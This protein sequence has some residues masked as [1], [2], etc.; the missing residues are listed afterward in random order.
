MV[1]KT[2]SPIGWSVILILFLISPSTA[3]GIKT[4]EGAESIQDVID[5]RTEIIFDGLVAFRRDLHR[6]PELSG[7]EKRTAKKITE[8]L[9]SLGLE[10][11]TGIGGHGVVGILRGGEKGRKI[12]WRADIDALKSDSPDVVEFASTNPGVRHI[13]GHDVH[14]A[15]GLGIADVLAA[16]RERLPGTVYFV[17][18]PSEEN[19]QGA[20]A[21]IDDG[22]FKSIAPEEFYALHVTPYPEGMIVSRPGGMFA[23]YGE[24]EIEY[25]SG[26]DSLDIVESVKKVLNRLETIAD[27]EVF[28]NPANWGDPEIGLVSP[29][30]IYGDYVSIHPG[31]Y[32]REEDNKLLISVNIGTTGSEL[33]KKAMK[34]L[35][36]ELENSK[37]SKSFKGMKYLDVT[38][39]P[40]NDPGLVKA[41]S[42]T[43]G[44][45]FG[46]DVYYEQFGV[47]SGGGDDFALFQKEVPGVYFYLGASDFDRNIVAE[48]HAPHF[49][50]DENCIRTGVKI[51]SI[52]ILDRLKSK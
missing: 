35:G 47:A 13:C 9:V 5:S 43:I 36:K 2:L 29:N 27:P 8:Y 1:L 25:E 23:D 48:T 22:L 46:T 12:A 37:F 38:Y 18:Q 50:V 4:G 32:I 17:F 39:N 30:T 40:V 3:Q 34:T 15:I 28:D 45:N 19:V 26:K 49:A 11:K 14:T 52:V 42:R 7:K 16:Q 51:F 31:Y 24:I 6:Y 33:L 20:K 41:V 21:M 10:V 44:E